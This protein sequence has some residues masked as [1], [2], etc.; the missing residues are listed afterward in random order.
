MLLIN[1]EFIHTK[2]KK[3]KKQPNAFGIGFGAYCQINY[4]ETSQNIFEL[5]LVLIVLP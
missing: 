5:P 4:R 1:D 3:K 2:K